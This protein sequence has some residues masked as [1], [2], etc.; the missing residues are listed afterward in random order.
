M[1]MQRPP[2]APGGLAEPDVEIY[3]IAE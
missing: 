3:T 2:A 1:N